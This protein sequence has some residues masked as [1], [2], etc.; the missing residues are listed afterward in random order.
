MQLLTRTYVWL[1]A[2]LLSLLAACGNA[3]DAASSAEE[4]VRRTVAALCE[5]RFEDIEGL[6]ITDD[7]LSWLIETMATGDSRQAKKFRKRHAEIGAAAMVKESRERVRKSFD[8]LRKEAA[9]E[10]VVWADVRFDR[11]HKLETVTADGVEAA[12]CYV[13]LRIGDKPGE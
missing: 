8:A 1:G 9:E 11:L 7:D 4:A 5:G 10:G 13:R 12:Q 2:C 3:D 6:L